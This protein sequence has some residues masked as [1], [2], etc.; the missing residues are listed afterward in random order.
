MAA[1][2]YA[3]PPRD[4]EEERKTRKLAG[5]R[6]APADWV[7]RA[8]MITA[9]W[10][11]KTVSAIAEELG[12]NP[13]TVRVR[14]HRFNAEGLDGLGDQ[15]I[16][17]RPPRLSEADRSRLVALVA[18]PPPGRPVRDEAGELSAAEETGAPEWTLDALAAAAQAEGI[19]VHRSQVR[20]ILL[21]E[22]VRWR[23]TRS[24]IRSKD[25]DFAGK[26]RGS[27]PSTPSHRPGRRSSASTSSGR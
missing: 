25:P 19:E 10:A 5:A 6:H 22:G 18:Q 8:R 11:G 17:G 2:L 4:A 14:L 16:P 21:A 1:P 20:R 23:R 12:C 9:S 24:W 13:K 7:L 27:S 26:G 3:R 15:S